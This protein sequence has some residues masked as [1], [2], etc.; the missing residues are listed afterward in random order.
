MGGK[1]IGKTSCR[2]SKG[3]VTYN[4]GTVDGAQSV[5]GGE[6]RDVMVI[7]VAF[8]LL[9]RNSRQRLR[10][11]G[12]FGGVHLLGARFLAH[13]ELFEGNRGLLVGFLASLRIMQKFVLLVAFHCD[14]L[15]DQQEEVR[16][17]LQVVVGLLVLL[18]QEIAN[19]QVVVQLFLAVDAVFKEGLQ[20]VKQ[21]LFIFLL[22]SVF[23]EDGSEVAVQREEGSIG[24]LFVVTLFEVFYGS[25]VLA[26]FEVDDSN[27]EE[28]V[29]PLENLSAVGLEELL[30]SAVRSAGLLAQLFLSFTIYLFCDF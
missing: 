9:L 8:G 15:L 2:L 13:F 6:R 3:G 23:G 12:Y 4:F 25:F 10:E 7:I 1:K 11:R 19:A 29:R 20:F 14:G 5:V 30:K 21:E 26:Q 16:V 18:Q 24:L 22:F 17:A 27:E 28:N